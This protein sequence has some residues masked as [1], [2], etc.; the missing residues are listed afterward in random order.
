MPKHKKVVW[1]KLDLPE[2]P[3]R[4]T[5]VEPGNESHYYW[6]FKPFQSADWQV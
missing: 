6:T 4:L 1:T 3:P 5:L 2:P